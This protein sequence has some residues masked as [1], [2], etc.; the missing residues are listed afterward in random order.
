MIPLFLEVVS[1]FS[2]ANFSGEC[3]KMDISK[4]KK[5]KV[6]ANSKAHYLAQRRKKSLFKKVSELSAL[7]G[8][9]VC[10]IV[11]DNQRPT[12]VVETWSNNRNDVLRMVKRCKG[13]T[14]E[15]QG[16]KPLRIQKTLLK[17]A[18]VKPTSTKSESRLLD[19][20]MITSQAHLA[21]SSQM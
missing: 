14:T 8:I 19:S 10:V 9:E 4:S 13:R 16:K 21:N 6:S 18:N 15:S 2:V 7:C 17:P 12:T 11:Y 1:R 5:L 3:Q 20:M